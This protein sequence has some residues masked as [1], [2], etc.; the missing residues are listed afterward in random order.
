MFHTEAPVSMAKNFYQN[1]RTQVKRNLH[2]VVRRVDMEYAIRAKTPVP[3][4]A[5]ERGLREFLSEHGFHVIHETDVKEI[6]EHYN[7]DYPE[8][9]ILKVVKGPTFAE[10]PMASAAVELDPSSGALLPP[11]IV[12]YEYEGETYVSAVRPSTLLAVFRD[13]DLRETIVELE[14][15]L[16]DAL[17]E[18]V[19]ESEMLSTEPPVRPGENNARERLKKRLNLV[20]SAVDAEYSVHVS[21]EAPP[22]TVRPQLRDAL[23][24]RGQHVLGEVAGG[25]IMLVVNPGQAHKALA[26]DPDVG[27]FAPLSVSVTEEDGRT[28]VRCVRP[29]TLLIFFDQPAMQDILMEMEMLLWN[30]LVTGVPDARIESRQPP[31]QPEGGQ[32]TTAAGLPGGLG[33]LR[34]QKD[35]RRRREEPQS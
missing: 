10:C 16:W 1:L 19:P 5:A 21:T 35:R 22:D 27:V 24:H 12:L 28:H 8:Y 2:P 32:R 26:I 17:A 29:T 7:I 31:L 6:H 34:R 30:S 3:F 20:L 4:E 23:A 25:Q 13:A 14:S 33:A 11:G 9:R 15:S 18:G